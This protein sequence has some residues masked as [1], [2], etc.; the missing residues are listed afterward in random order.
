M[1]WTRSC[2]AAVCVWFVRGVLLVPGVVGCFGFFLR[3]SPR[4]FFLLSAL[5][6][7]CRGARIRGHSPETDA[8]THTGAGMSTRITRIRSGTL[9]LLLLL[10]V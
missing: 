1:K 8:A 2:A 7:H 4:Y 10:L 6:W 5:P 9:R 3:A